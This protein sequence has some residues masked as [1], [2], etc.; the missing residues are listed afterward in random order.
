MYLS[1]QGVLQFQLF[2]IPMVGAD[3]GGF[4]GNSDEELVN[5]WMQVRIVTYYLQQNLLLTLFIIQLSAFHPFYRNH[6]Q[7]GAIGQEPYVWDSVA[8]ASRTAIAAR[9]AL[10][11]YW[12]HSRPLTANSVTLSFDHVCSIRSLRIPRSA[13]HLP[14]V[15]CFGSSPMSPSYLR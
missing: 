10:L 4:N 8:N 1:I 14:F 12:V 7:R 3:T 2:Q 6:N 11:P 5:R 15:R 13:V 9:Y